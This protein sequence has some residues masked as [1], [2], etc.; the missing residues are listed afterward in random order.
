MGRPQDNPAAYLNSS[1]VSQ[2]ANLKGKLMIAHATG[3][4]NVHFTNTSEVIN[5]LILAEKYPA[6]LMIFPGR[7]HGMTD[8]PARI[9]LFNG[10]TDFLLNNL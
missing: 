7:G 6:R 2:A 9:Q 10:I 8:T 3:D 4:D 5:Q 1:A